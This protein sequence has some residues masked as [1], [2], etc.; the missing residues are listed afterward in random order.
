MQYKFFYIPAHWPADAEAEVNSFLTGHA[1]QTV[2]RQ[3][4]SAGKQSGWSLCVVYELS[5]K[6][7][8]SLRK[9]GSIDY[10][11][12]L[13]AADFDVY[14]E[15][16]RLRKRLAEEQAV[17][18]YTVF[19]NEQ[20]ASMVTRKVRTLEPQRVRQAQQQPGLPPCRSSSWSIPWG[21]AQHPVSL[22]I[23]LKGKTKR[24]GT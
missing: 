20:L 12:V 2:D 14:A 9:K 11:E 5:S 8:P 6:Q 18:A 10:R 4:I 1:I 19:S 16:R 13:D 3:F 17:P 22:A 15:L 7:N 23:G 21:P 24:P